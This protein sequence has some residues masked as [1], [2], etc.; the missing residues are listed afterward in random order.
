MPRNEYRFGEDAMATF[1]SM[2]YDVLKA[3]GRPL[4]S[5]E[6]MK[7]ARARGFIT[8]GKTPAATMAA[9]LYV[10]VNTK[11][12]KSA[13]VKADAPSTF[14]LNSRYASAGSAEAAIQEVSYPLA[15]NLSPKQKGV[16]AEARVAE[17][18][19]LYGS[20]AL[21]CFQPM[22]DDDGIDLVVKEKG[23]LDRTIF[24][25]V[26]S[27]FGS[28]EGTFTATTRPPAV[29][30]KDL[31]FVFCLFDTAEGD[32]WDSLWFIPA[33]DFLTKANK[34]GSGDYAFVAGMR[35]R[36]SNKFNDYLIDKRALASQISGLMHRPA[37]APRI[38]VANGE[39]MRVAGYV[40]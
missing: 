11:G 1:K 34:L 7:R 19:T 21:S 30:T 4:H 6:I 40:A 16:I 29:A 22:S 33:D 38:A 37:S 36:E 24:L 18:I 15:P 14:G 23:R 3:A 2:A 35:R 10:D 26:K 28:P 17:L 20:T 27:R 8:E 32:L 12:D 5:A 39:T 9:V 25:Q 31:A 13:F